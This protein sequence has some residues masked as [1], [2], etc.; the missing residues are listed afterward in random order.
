MGLDMYAYAA[1]RAGQDAEFHANAK[2]DPKDGPGSYLGGHC[3]EHFCTVNYLLN[4]VHF[5]PF[6]FQNTWDINLNLIQVGCMH[7]SKDDT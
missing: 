3:S 4:T 1:A 2:F 6:I 5:L 7:S